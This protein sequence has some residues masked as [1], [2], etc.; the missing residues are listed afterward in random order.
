[1]DNKEKEFEFYKIALDTRN[2]E[3]KLF[4]QRSNYF[5]VLNSGLAFGFFKLGS[6]NIFYSLLLSIMGIIT[7]LLW[8]HVNLG[9]KFWQIRW[10]EKLSSME[11]EFD[12]K[13]HFF[14]T[15]DE[16]LW[17]DVQTN[18]SRDNN[19]KKFLNRDI[20]SKTSV[21]RN[22]IYL[23]LLFSVSWMIISCNIIWTSF[24]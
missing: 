13:I 5:L 1:M 3:I 7:S 19:Y 24:T 21:S 23:S 15:T 10:E 18:L 8:Y 6:E 22:M 20:L 14:N 12:K 9:S 2:F 16:I 4:W 11:K 17:N